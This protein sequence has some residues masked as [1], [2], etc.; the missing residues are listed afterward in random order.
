MIDQRLKEHVTSQV[1]AVGTAQGDFESVI[2][3]GRTRRRTT[4]GL[5]AAAAILFVLGFVGLMTQLPVEQVA[6]L[7]NEPAADLEVVVNPGDGPG[8]FAGELAGSIGPVVVPGSADHIGWVETPQGLFDLV[9]FTA[10]GEDRRRPS[11]ELSSCVGATSAASTP[12]NRGFSTGSC[13]PSELPVLSGGYGRDDFYWILERVPPDTV[14]LLVTTS[15]EKRIEILTSDYGFAAWP[16]TWGPAESLTAYDAAS[17][18][19]GSI[20]Y[21]DS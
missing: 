6:F 18:P 2:R 1:N 9:T 19:T 7:G 12:E 8:S 20:N 17:N 5:Q 3:R 13:H 11:S 10:V 14:R 16:T 15:Q 21:E 4:L